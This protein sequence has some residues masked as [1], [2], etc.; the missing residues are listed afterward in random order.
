MNVHVATS[1]EDALEFKRGHPAAHPLLG[2]TD[3][4]AQWQ[5]G[6][7]RPEHV[8]ALE[9]LGDL[10][11]VDIGRE[12]VTIG[13][14][15]SHFT[16]AHDAVMRERLPALAAAAR[17]VGAPA[18][19]MMGTLAGNIANASPA[20]DVPPVLL[21][22]GAEVVAA[23]VEGERR[24]PLERF[25]TAYRR[26]ALAPQE[27]VVAVF[28]PWPREGTYADYYKIGTRAAQSIARVGLAGCLLAERGTVTR[29]RLGAASVA[30][31]PVR[32]V[33]VERLVE[34]GALSADLAARARDLA[35]ACVSPIDDVRGTA[36]YRR[37]ALGALVERFL[38]RAAAATA[39]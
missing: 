8:L 24:I 10:K 5:A 28:V 1:L 36:A 11:R 12:G 16:L 27:L 7:P 32:L 31:T 18:I 26:T 25:Y 6:A 14:G 19:Q 9:A 21:A 22:Y 35:A 3:A 20:A 38:T 23:A 4:I 29:A 33:D 2:G 34:G 39:A 37:R 13:A 15:V 17:T 30:P